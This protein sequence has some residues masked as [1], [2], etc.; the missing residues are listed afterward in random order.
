MLIFVHK[1]DFRLTK[2]VQDLDLSKPISQNKLVSNNLVGQKAPVVTLEMGML[3]KGCFMGLE[4]LVRR[5]K[6]YSLNLECASTNSTIYIITGPRLKMLEKMP[7][8][9][10]QVV[11]YASKN[12]KTFEK[13]FIQIVK[14]RTKFP[15]GQRHPKA[16]DPE[17]Q[18]R[19]RRETTRQLTMDAQQKMQRLQAETKQ[20]WR[21]VKH[22][23]Q[24][25]IQS[26]QLGKEEPVVPAP[27]AKSVTAPAPYAPRYSALQGSSLAQSTMMGLSGTE[28]GTPAAPG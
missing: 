28:Y 20:N 7:R 4:D 22:D 12:A 8:I 27:A 23:R 9:W 16:F 25:R 17:A 14:Q 2:Q 3:S 10:A 18:M 13:Q 19:H 1:G 15:F 6:N 21:Q 11:D 26:F 5:N 24:A